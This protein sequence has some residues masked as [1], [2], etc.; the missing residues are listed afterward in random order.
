MI[1][2]GLFALAILL[3]ISAGVSA[4]RL[5]HSD[6]FET[7]P[8]ATE[9][10]AK[11]VTFQWTESGP[12][13]LEAVSPVVV[14]TIPESVAS[15]VDS[16]IN[17]IHVT[18]SKTMKDRTWAWA[19]LSMDSFPRIDGDPR[20]L[21][22]ERTCVLPVRLAPGKTYAI[23]INTNKHLRFQDTDGIPAVPYLLVFKTAN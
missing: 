1:R 23:W 15:N 14:K 3:V 13:A 12:V 21:C 19:T 20:Y 7:N 6:I 16:G 2:N 8:S 11:H 5:S 9:S 17:E 18:F 4:Q 22:D 10:N